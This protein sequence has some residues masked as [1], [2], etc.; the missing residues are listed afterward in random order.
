MVSR[1]HPETRADRSRPAGA[2][3]NAC[4]RTWSPRSVGCAKPCATRFP[5]TMGDGS[6]R[7]AHSAHNEYA[8]SAALD[9]HAPQHQSGS[10]LCRGSRR[11]GSSITKRAIRKEPSP[12]AICSEQIEKYRDDLQR[13]AKILHAFDGMPRERRPIL[14]AAAA[15]VRGRPNS[16]SHVDRS[17]PRVRLGHL[18]PQLWRVRHRAFAWDHAWTAPAWHSSARCDVRHRRARWQV[19]H[20]SPRLRNPRPALL[21]DGAGRRA[22]SRRVLRVGNAADRGAPRSRPAI[23]RRDFLFGNS[24]LR[25]S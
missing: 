22:A 13:Y 11:D 19:G 20:R 3:R 21:H 23:A 15:L 5:M 17:H 8:L 14:P 6:C 9:E 7:S 12:R 1:P 2:G 18:P 25:F 24:S 16:V 4:R 10:D